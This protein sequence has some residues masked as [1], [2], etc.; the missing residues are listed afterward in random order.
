MC[1]WLKPQILKIDNLVFCFLYFVCCWIALSSQY[2]LRKQAIELYPIISW[3]SF[4]VEISANV[5]VGSKRI[6]PTF[7]CL[8][9]LVSLTL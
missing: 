8:Q 6:C 5:W 2:S 7:V 4:K 1:L 3:F 9:P